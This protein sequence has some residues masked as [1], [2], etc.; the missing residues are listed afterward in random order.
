[1]TMNLFDSSNINVFLDISTYCNAGCPQCHRTSKN[2]KLKKVDWLPLI[3]WSLEDFQKAFPIEEMKNVNKFSI[4]GTWGDPIM[5]KDFD[6]IV[7]YILSNTDENKTWVSVH[8]NGS[9]R[10][11]E[12]WWKL[13]AASGKRLRV[14]F[15]VDGINQEMHERYR[16]FTILDKV[17]T[18]MK[19]ISE[20]NSIINSQTIIFKHNYNY[21]DQIMKICYD[22]GSTSH[23]YVM[24]DRFENKYST[25][26]KYFHFQ[27]EFG[28]KDILEKSKPLINGTISGTNTDTLQKKI[29]CR[30]ALPRNEIVVNPDGMVFP[31]C[32]HANLFF[33]HS[34]NNHLHSRL[35][36]SKVYE[37]YLKTPN[38]YNI[39]Y[40]P[41]SKILNSNWYSQIL[42]N[43]FKSKTPLDICVRQCSSLIK[44]THQLRKR[45]TIKK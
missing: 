1:M 10:D 14:V 24:S 19:S 13:G 42:P 18:N 9:L 17:L 15:A 44:K 39:F 25:E 40:T 3:Q 26:E 36:E 22:N 30:W 43:S 2:N 12:W 7:D 35:K 8:T 11:E 32:Y 31:C 45:H 28:E 41:L 34:Q 29:K 21:K 38:K 23:E 4:C 5:N 20:T 33:Y 16:R 27:N 6:K 37:E